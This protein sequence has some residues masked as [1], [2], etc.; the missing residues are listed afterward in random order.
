MAM[1]TSGFVPKGN[2]NADSDALKKT[3]RKQTI[4]R[5]LSFLAKYRIRIVLSICLSAVSVIFTLLVP[6]R[7]GNAIDALDLSLIHI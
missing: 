6:I 3:G 5:V 2:L 4:R 1:D 7:I